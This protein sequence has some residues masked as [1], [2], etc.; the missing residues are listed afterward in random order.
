MASAFIDHGEAGRRPW[1]VGRSVGRTVYIQVGEEP[2]KDDLLVG[3]KRSAFPQV[4]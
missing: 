3:M 4:P 1:R 2:G